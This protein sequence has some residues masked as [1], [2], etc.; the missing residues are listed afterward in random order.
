MRENKKV[1]SHLSIIERANL[2]LGA[3]VTRSRFALFESK[4]VSFQEEG[5]AMNN[6]KQ[7]RTNVC[8]SPTFLETLYQAAL[9]VWA[10]GGRLWWRKEVDELVFKCFFGIGEEYYPDEYVEEAVADDKTLYDRD[11]VLNAL[12]GVWR[13]IY[14]GG[15]WTADMVRRW[16][17]RSLH[18][19]SHKMNPDGSR[20]EAPDDAIASIDAGVDDLPYFEPYRDDEDEEK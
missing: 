17:Q 19:A 6:E 13:L 9:A 5:R 14:G 2:N 4:K 10:Q 11:D 18:L 1:P 8:A 15:S 12:F 7:S 3:M 20:K 16:V